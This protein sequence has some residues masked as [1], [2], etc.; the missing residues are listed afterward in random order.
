MWKFL[1][2]SEQQI[3]LKIV[4]DC[5]QS[6]RWSQKVDDP[7]VWLGVLDKKLW[8]LRQNSDGIEYKVFD[9]TTV[10]VDDNNSGTFV[11]N[12]LNNNHVENEKFLRDYFQL[13]IDIPSLYEKWSSADKNFKGLQNQFCGIRMLRQ[14]PVENLF[15]FICSQNNNIV[16][17]KQ[18]VNKLC[19]TYG[20]KA[21]CYQDVDYYSFPSMSALAQPGVEKKLRELGFGYRAKFI[22]GTA[23][24]IDQK[25]EGEEWLYNLRNVPYNEAHQDLC[26]LPGVGAKVADC[27]CLMSLDKSEAIPVDTHM[28]Q[29]ASRDYLPHLK[30]NKTL[31]DKTY[32]E[33][34]DFFRELYGNYAGWAHS[35]LFSADL[36][37]FQ[38]LKTVEASLKPIQKRS[39]AGRKQGRSTEVKKRKKK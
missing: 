23:S 28:W 35:V 31:T 7:S 32:K 24:C 11:V 27:V 14:D 18:L 6:F 10:P 39:K 15:S 9:K 2:C 12:N 3:N 21:V 20:H 34:G 38:E 29:I 13:D 36:K 5:G 4:L 16:R 25:E 26:S 19:I 37:K 33:I 22:Q 17:I 1:R 8:F 30:K